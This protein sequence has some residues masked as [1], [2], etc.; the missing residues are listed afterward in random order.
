MLVCVLIFMCTKQT[1]LVRSLS[2]CVLCTYIHISNI[3]LYFRSAETNKHFRS[4]TCS[5]SRYLALSLFFHAADTFC[6][7]VCDCELLSIR[8]ELKSSGPV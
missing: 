1:A 2:V 5:Y 7:C 6:A 4:F 8:A 3:K